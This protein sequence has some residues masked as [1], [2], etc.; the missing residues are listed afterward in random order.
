MTRRVPR[1]RFDR[2]VHRR[3]ELIGVASDLGKEQ[4]A[5]NGCQRVLG[6]GACVRAGVQSPR[7]AIRSRP[8]RDRGLPVVQAAREFESSAFVLLR[9]PT[10]S[11]LLDTQAAHIGS[12]DVGSTVLRWRRAALPLAK[13]TSSDTRRGRLSRR[14]AAR[15][16]WLIPA[17][18]LLFLSHGH[19]TGRDDSLAMRGK[20][21][22]RDRQRWPRVP[23]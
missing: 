12:E 6:K 18:A 16:P 20:E 11:W 15:L 3:A 8:W 7:A 13:Q 19:L 5:L 4:A 10:E 21:G 2:A 1:D 23:M 14:A 17:P 9:C 22:A